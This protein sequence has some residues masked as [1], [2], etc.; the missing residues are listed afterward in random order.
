MIRVMVLTSALAL[1]GCLP[2]ANAPGVARLGGPKL[3]HTHE[4]G[5]PNARPGACWGKEV[6]PAVIET[7]TEQILIQ[8]AQLSSDGEVLIPP[9]YKAE[10]QPRIVE[11]RRELWFET[12]CIEAQTPEFIASL[13]RALKA[14]GH[15]QGSPTGE[16]DTRTLRA[17]RRYQAEQGL[18]SAILTLAAARRLGLVAIEVP[19]RAEAAE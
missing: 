14:R 4:A 15:Y 2:G 7:V 1:S 11:E 16:M 17:V 19:R 3:I 12:P 9:I 10:T 6:T 8:P 18:D 13:Q 5:P